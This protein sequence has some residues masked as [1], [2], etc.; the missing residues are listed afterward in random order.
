MVIVVMMISCIAAFSINGAK[1]LTV[2]LALTDQHICLRSYLCLHILK[3]L[4][5]I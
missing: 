3:S 2:S 1:K 4:Y 5:F